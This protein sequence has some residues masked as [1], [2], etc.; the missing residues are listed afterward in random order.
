LLLIREAQNGGIF[1]A[2]TSSAWK[3]HKDFYGNSDCF[4]FRLMPSTAVYYP[5]GCGSN[6]MY[7]NSKIRGRGYDILAHGI[8]FGGTTEK[9]RLFISKNLDEC[10]V[11]NSDSTFDPGS[12][13]PERR[14]EEDLGFALMEQEFEVESLEVWG[15]GGNDIVQNALGIRERERQIFAANIQKAKKVDKSQF[16]N[17]FKSGL[18]NSKVFQHRDEMRG[19]ADC[20][21]DDN[22]P[23]NYIYDK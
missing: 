12:L 11:V 5:T 10:I 18:M 20:H 4:L 14:H 15:I 2:F 3:E 16:L 23:R 8:G 9:P 1:G 19:R 17:D 22:D 21:V 6:Y 13:L 7:C